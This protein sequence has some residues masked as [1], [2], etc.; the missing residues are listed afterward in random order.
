MVRAS[1]DSCSY[2]IFVCGDF[3]DGPLTYTYFKIAKGLRDSY[4]SKGKYPGY[5][6]DNF[7]I[8][9]R[10]DYILYDDAFDCTSHKVIQSELSD[11]YAVVAEFDRDE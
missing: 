11:H 8:K 3:N 5:T 10:I 4:S 6:W 2:P 1:I 7:K 9:Q